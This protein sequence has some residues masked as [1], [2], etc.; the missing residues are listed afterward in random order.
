MVTVKELLVTYVGPR[1]VWVLA[2]IGIDDRLRGDEV[3]GLARAIEMGLRHRSA[4]V[5][6]VDVV[7]VGGDPGTPQL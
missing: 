7:P 5:A 2:R 6:R 3:D 1:Q 4:H